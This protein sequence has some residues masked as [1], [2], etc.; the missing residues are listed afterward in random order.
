MERPNPNLLLCDFCKHRFR[1]S[2][3][4]IYPRV[5]GDDGSVVMC[6][7]CWAESQEIIVGDMVRILDK[8]KHWTPN[9]VAL[10]AGREAKIVEYAATGRERGWLIEIYGGPMDGWRIW[11]TAAEFTV[12]EEE[13]E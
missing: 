3:L 13:G 11:A 7:Q 5:G 10:Y 2:E 8:P 12:I 6:F 4:A 1:R 9:E